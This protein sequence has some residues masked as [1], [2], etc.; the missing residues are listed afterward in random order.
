M[1]RRDS[2]LVDASLSLSLSH[3]HTHTHIHTLSCFRFSG[4]ICHPPSQ[5]FVSS[6]IDINYIFKLREAQVQQRKGQQTNK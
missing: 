4:G 2:G 3:T 6:K 1:I 5:I